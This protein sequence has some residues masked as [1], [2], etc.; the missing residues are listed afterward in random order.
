MSTLLGRLHKIEAGGIRWHIQ[1]GWEERLLGPCGLRLDEWLRGGQAQIVKEGP[2]RTVYRIHLADACLYLKHYRLAD[3]KARLR[4]L[5]RPAKAFREFQHALALS[6][7]AVPTVL[8][9]AMGERLGS[10]SGRESYFITRG[11]D[12]VQPLGRFLEKDLPL[13]GDGQQTP[14]RHQVAAALGVFV[15]RLHEAGIAHHDLH[16][17]NI[18][19][20]REESGPALFL[21]DLDAV[22]PVIA[23][24]LARQLRQ[25]GSFESLFQLAG[26]PIRSRAIL[27]RLLHYETG[28]QWTARNLRRER[29]SPPGG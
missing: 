17:A 15:A 6:D 8:P 3:L 25:P 26:L 10:R 14:A 18:M 20:R 12:D 4:Q 27:A 29:P 16:V 23:T 9:L 13:L 11:L 19:I 22:S 1:P 21:L 24:F 5:I 28:E 2:H 7:R